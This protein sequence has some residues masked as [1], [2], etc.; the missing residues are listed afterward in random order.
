[1]PGSKRS[2][3]F[4]SLLL[5]LPRSPPKTEGLKEGEKNGKWKGL[6]EFCSFK[7]ERES[8]AI[9]L[10]E[11]R[12]GKGERGEGVPSLST[13]PCRDAMRFLG[14]SSDKFK[15]SGGKPTARGQ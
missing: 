7:S 1:V 2:T 12:K 15:K 8:R 3:V 4:L 6:M 14:L 10:L 9:D 13:K 5:S 11:A